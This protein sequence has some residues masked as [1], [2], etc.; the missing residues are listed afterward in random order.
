M[1]WDIFFK[2]I[3][4]WDKE[5]CIYGAGDCGQNWGFELIKLAGFKICCYIDN[6]VN[7]KECNGYPIRRAEFIENNKEL[8]YFI[9]MSPKSAIE[10]QEQLRMIGVDNYFVFPSYESYLKELPAELEI[11]N[12][13]YL[14]K[15]LS[16]ITDDKEYLE[17][18]YF[19]RLGKEL[20]LKNPTKFSEKMQWL[21]LYDRK[22]L[23]TRLVDKYEVKKWVEEK[24]GK[25]HV[26]P[27]YGVWD[28][29]DDINFDELPETFVL[30]TNHSS[31]G[32]IICKDKNTFDKD[33]AK[34]ELEDSLKI[35]T[36]YADREWPYKNVKPKIIAEKYIETLCKPDSVEY[37][38]T[39]MNG[40]PEFVTICKGVAHSSF[41]AR[42]NNHYDLNFK[43]IPFYAFYKNSKEG[44]KKPKQWNEILGIACVLAADIPTVRVDFY[45]DKGIVYFGEM[46]FFTWSGFPPFV[47]EE[48]DEIFGEKLCLPKK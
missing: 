42:T 34:K 1:K 13:E 30:K 9:L 45:I 33:A 46:T 4:N 23:Y 27:L 15:K 12:D 40:K 16:F 44:F 20:N 25:E 14:N 41:D 10:V 26:V 2:Y 29:F 17:R 38:V 39:C 7:Q 28:S 3:K 8:L 32:V 11:T 43:E 6:Y 48:Y 5:V 36:Y 35:N 24:I 47:P 18:R 37:K 22:D 31:D 19:Q 21:K